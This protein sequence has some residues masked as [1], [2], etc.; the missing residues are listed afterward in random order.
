M[1][2]EQLRAARV[3]LVRKYLETPQAWPDGID[4]GSHWYTMN[5]AYWDGLAK[6]EPANSPANSPANKGS[7]VANKSPVVSSKPA[8]KDSPVSKPDRAEYMRELMRKKRA[9]A[10]AAK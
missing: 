6:A 5:K 8:N 1:T 4:W 3:S 10:K 7:E 9:A 2:D